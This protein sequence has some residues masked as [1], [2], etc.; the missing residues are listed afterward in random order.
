MPFQHRNGQLPN[1]DIFVNLITHNVAHYKDMQSISTVGV[2]KDALAVC[3][4]GAVILVYL[5]CKHQ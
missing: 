1:K 2:P 4:V 5:Y 3:Y